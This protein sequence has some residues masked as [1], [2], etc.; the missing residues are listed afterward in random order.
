MK[1]YGP[2][3]A[4]NA[5][6]QNGFSVS[7]HPRFPKQSR[8]SPSGRRTFLRLEALEDRCLPSGISHFLYEPV[9]A[10]PFAWQNQLPSDR[11]L[12]NV[13]YDF[14]PRNGFPNLITPEQQE[15]VGHALGMWSSVTGGRLRFTQSTTAPLTQIINIGTG[16]L[17]AIGEISVPQGIVGQGGN[18][19]HFTTFDQRNVLEQGYA[20]MDFAETYDEQLGNG[21][22][23]GTIEYFT[24]AAHEIGHALGLGHLDDLPGPSIMDSGRVGEQTTPS[25]SEVDLIQM[26]YPLDF[27]PAP[28]ALVAAGADAGGAPEVR[29]FL[30][31]SEVLRLAAYDPRFTGGVRVAV[32]DING[33]QYPDVVT[34]PGPG[35]GP[36]IHVFDGLTGNLSR[37][38]F[39]FDPKFTGGVFVA[40]G[41]VNGDGFDDIVCGADA[42]GGPAVSAVS[43][44][45]ASVLSTFFAFDP[46]FTG[47]V[48]VAAGDVNADGRA[49]II[50]GAGPG[51][52]PGVSVFTGDGTLVS[53]FFA[54][55]PLFTGGIFVAAGDLNG[56]G[57]SDVVTGACAGGGPDVAW[58]D[59]V[60][61]VRLDNFFA[62]D[63][64]FTGGV[65]VGTVAT[66]T[67][68]AAIVAAPGP[69][70]APQVQLRDPA[71]GHAVVEQFDAYQAMFTGGV[72]VA[73]RG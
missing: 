60:S 67:G 1:V 69:G 8:G 18:D 23:T 71:P 64:A 21:T 22:P 42:G 44:R 58:F 13:F 20:W 50:A 2:K 45:D 9:N 28:P 6:E 10:E 15:L 19:R 34:A 37:Q 61:G 30:G 40:T 17:R 16:D 11:A 38:F 33:D 65:R 4:W 7:S 3:A 24:V 47:G 52:G 32:G 46:L 41:D 56:D 68:F 43:G 26:L 70:G 5:L 29:V 39:A 53:S 54:Y 36:D 55:N 72:F 27:V 35:G 59:A 51:G 48:R 73:A 14:R 66:A 25:A 63:P 49:D 62:F 57:R 12:V 31:S